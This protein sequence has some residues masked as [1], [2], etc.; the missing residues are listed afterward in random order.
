MNYAWPAA[1]AFIGMCFAIAYAN[2]H[3]QPPKDAQVA[4]IEQ[5]GKWVRDWWDG[6][7]EFPPTAS[8]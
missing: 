3:A 6:T 4:C 7:C 1:I 5:H 8:R 2:T